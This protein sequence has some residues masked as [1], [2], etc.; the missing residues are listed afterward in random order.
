MKFWSKHWKSSKKPGKQ[1]KYVYHAPI[2]VRHKFL[3][4]HLSKEL[5]EKYKKRAFP[6]RKGDEVQ[7]MR[8]KFKKKTGKISRVD[9]NKIKIYI[10]GITRKKVEGTEIQVPIHPSNL[11]IINLNLEDK[12][13][14]NALTRTVKK[15]EKN[16]ETSEKVVSSK[17]LEGA[18]KIKKMGSVT[19]TRSS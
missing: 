4:A 1:R 7:I 11:K 19:K 9:L 5:R 13:R 8:G 10:D 12:K 2:H 15:E 6:V 14:I 3:S 18:N 17:V 16:V